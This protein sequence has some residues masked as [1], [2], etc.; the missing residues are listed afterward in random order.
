MSGGDFG[1]LVNA[2]DLGGLPTADGRRI[3]HGALVRADSPHRLSAAGWD[4]L[5]NAGV[6]TVIDLRHG[7]EREEFVDAAPRP[8]GVTSLWCQLE[9]PDDAEFIKKWWA[10][11]LGPFYYRDAVERYDHQLVRLVRAVVGAPDGSVLFHCML[12]RDRTGLAALVLLALAGVPAETIAAD[13]ALSFPLVRSIDRHDHLVCEL[14]SEQV[15]DHRR[16]IVDLLDE[17]DLASSLVEA[18][19]AAGELER[20]R[21]RLVA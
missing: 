1:E 6:R 19:L 18:G 16:A 14:A 10:Q 9:D 13:H 12:G 21:R 20:L 3:R 2:R 7:R 8:D 4:A 5:W 11:L 15:A 17:I